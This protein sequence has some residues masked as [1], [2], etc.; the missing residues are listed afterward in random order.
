MCE[1][2]SNILL[3]LIEWSGMEQKDKIEMI[4]KECDVYHKEADIVYKKVFLLFIIEGGIASLLFNGK[5]ELLNVILIIP[6]LFFILGIYLNYD[7]LNKIKLKIV[8]LE[9]EIERVKN[10]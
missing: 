4:N 2:K 5:I 10:G 7:R 8:E 6:F 1:S 9:N 3:S